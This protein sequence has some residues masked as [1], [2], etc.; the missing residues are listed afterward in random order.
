M[1]IL[2]GGKATQYKMGGGKIKM[3]KYYS[4]GGTIYTGR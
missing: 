4:G 2:Y 1:K 3:A